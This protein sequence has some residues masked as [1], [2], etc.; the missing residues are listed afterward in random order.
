M[1]TMKI[2]QKVYN[3]LIK[4][5]SLLKEAL[6]KR[7]IILVVNLLKIQRR[8]KKKVAAEKKEYIF[9][10]GIICLDLVSILYFLVV[11]RLARKSKN[12]VV[13]VI[14]V[15]SYFHKFKFAN[16]LLGLLSNSRFLNLADKSHTTDDF[17][18]LLSGENVSR[19]RLLDYFIN[20]YNYG[21]NI[22]TAIL[23]NEKIGSF[24][25]INANKLILSKTYWDNASY[26]VKKFKPKMMLISH[27]S[28][29]GF[30][31][32]F[33]NALINDIYTVALIP[34]GKDYIA[35]KCYNRLEDFT[36]KNKSFYLS[37]SNETIDIV[38]EHS[39]KDIHEDLI[40]KYIETRFNGNDCLFEGYYHKNTIKICEDDLKRK[41]KINTKYR[42]IVLLACHL[43]WDD[44]LHYKSVYEDYQSWFKETL[45]SLKKKNDIFI[46]VKAHPAEVARGTNKSCFQDYHDICNDLGE[47][48]SVFLYGNSEINT[49]SLIALCDIVFTVRG[50]IGLEAL[51]MGKP[52]IN[53]GESPYSDLG[54][55]N[56]F[57]D[58]ASY[59]DF[60]K[61]SMDNI[62]TPSEAQIKFAKYFTYF[63]FNKGLQSKIVNKNSL[64]YDHILSSQ[65]ISHLED[66][67]IDHAC[68]K[69]LGMTVGDITHINR[70][71]I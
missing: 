1:E 62:S 55:T 21:V 16:L 53:V 67:A 58:K 40:E 57:K 7:N 44:P 45:R 27:Q 3:K 8:Y 29:D 14:L 36:E 24:D 46:I 43:Y 11:T 6:S 28:Y 30:G 66:N 71:D 38:R 9:I 13:P 20:N 56:D 60:I 48:N 51:C 70:H 63:Y 19:N 2:H 10:D 64:L 35:G 32:L 33:G 15:K 52:V 69:I 68:D 61:T 49:Y 47:E 50:T 59:L 34:Y 54:M 39:E 41:L 22:Y 12:K 26:Y 42:K 5:I 25:S 37:L 23:R 4:I 17:N 18:D 31:S 65:E